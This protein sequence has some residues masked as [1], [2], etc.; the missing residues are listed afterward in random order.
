MT[1]FKQLLLAISFLFA[2]EGYCQ[3]NKINLKNSSLTNLLDFFLQETSLKYDSLHLINKELGVVL[4]EFYRIDKH[5]FPL[6]LF[7]SDSIG[8]L[9]GKGKYELRIS[10]IFH[11]DFFLKWRPS[12]FSFYKNRPVAFFTGTEYFIDN[13][14]IG[15]S[16]LKKCSAHLNNSDH[17]FISWIVRIDESDEAKNGIEI[18]KKSVY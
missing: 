15:N 2:I 3:P 18:L 11:Q 6:G 12:F 4:I 8:P 14:K 17:I 13:E 1:N 5:F 7:P 10:M 9:A 16:F